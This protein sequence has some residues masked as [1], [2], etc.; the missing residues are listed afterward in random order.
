MEKQSKYE[1]LAIH[2]KNIRKLNKVTINSIVISAEGVVSKKLSKTIE[3]LA[4][5]SNILRVSQKTI[6]LQTCH[7]VRKFLN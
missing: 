7:I 5:P 6:L 2:F 4:I 1:E 3:E